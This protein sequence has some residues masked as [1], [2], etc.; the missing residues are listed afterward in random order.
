M[1]R[2]TKTMKTEKQIR[3]EAQRDMYNRLWDSI[4]KE[5]TVEA[6]VKKLLEELLIIREELDELRKRKGE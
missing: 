1:K 5:K 3:W 2:C 6:G 4:Y